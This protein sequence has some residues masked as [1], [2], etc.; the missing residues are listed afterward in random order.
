VFTIIYFFM[1]GNFRMFAEPKIK[2]NSDELESPESGLEEPLVSSEFK[3]N[4][5]INDEST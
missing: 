4:P 5:S 3:I 1:Q 2:Y